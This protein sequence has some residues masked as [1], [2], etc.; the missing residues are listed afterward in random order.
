M[1]WSGVNAGEGFEFHL[2]ALALS[3]PLIV[4]GGGAW[5]LDRWLS[6]RLA[7]RGSRSEQGVSHFEAKGATT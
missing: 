2:L 6:K 4:R 3:L 5:S 1:N 7:A